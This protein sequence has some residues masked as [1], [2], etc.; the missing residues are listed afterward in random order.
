VKP[1]EAIQQELLF[2]KKHGNETIYQDTMNLEEKLKATRDMFNI[3][4]KKNYKR[5]VRK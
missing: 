3:P 4:K 5:K 1:K 2:T